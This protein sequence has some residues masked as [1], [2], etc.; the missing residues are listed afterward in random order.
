M[1]QLDSYPGPNSTTSSNIKS[2]L[3]LKTLSGITNR[4]YVHIN[5]HRRPPITCQMTNAGHYHKSDK[6]QT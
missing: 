5:H 1:I 6:T 4:P 3:Q 2:T